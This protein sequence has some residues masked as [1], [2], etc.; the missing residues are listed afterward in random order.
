MYLTKKTYIGNKY[1]KPEQQVTIRMPKNQDGVLFKTGTIKSERIESIVESVGYWRKANAIHKWFVDNVQE[2]EDDC[3]SYSV[4]NGDLEN[5]LEIVEKVLKASK[6]VFRDDLKGNVVE[7][8]SDP[9]VAKEL[10][11]SEDGF[12]FGGTEYD[13]YYYDDL[14][15]TKKIIKQCLKEDDCDFY[16]QSSW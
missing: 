12:F 8:I 9:K 7:V 13:R 4:S 2:G 15:E 3:K 14:V 5:L 6:L 10:L 11:P 1:R 16:Y